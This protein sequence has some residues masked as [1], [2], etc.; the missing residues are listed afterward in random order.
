MDTWKQKQNPNFLFRTLSSIHLPIYRM[1][2]KIVNE[3]TIISSKW[4]NFFARLVQNHVQNTRA[5][6]FFLVVIWCFGCLLAFTEY[7]ILLHFM[8]L[9]PLLDF[10]KCLLTHFLFFT[11][12]L[13]TSLW[14]WLWYN[15]NHTHHRRLLSLCVFVWSLPPYPHDH[16]HH[17]NH[18]HSASLCK[19][20][21]VWL[22]LCCWFYAVTVYKGMGALNPH[23]ITPA[24]PVQVTTTAHTRLYFPLSRQTKL[25]GRHHLTVPF[26]PRFSACI[27]NNDSISSWAWCNHLTRRKNIAL[28][29]QFFCLRFAKF[30]LFALSHIHIFLYSGDRVEEEK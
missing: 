2:N 14:L 11:T 13:T 26:L 7:S 8:H 27:I 28:F 25:A 6:V 18:Q 21:I 16:D 24:A 22:L 19:K 5:L 4:T 3:H 1:P 17:Q 10:M 29:R 15:C 12:S 30:S 9:K 23:G 20:I